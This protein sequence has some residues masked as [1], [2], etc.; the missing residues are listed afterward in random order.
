MNPRFRKQRPIAEINIT[1]FTDVIL[2]LLIIFMVT[3]PLILQ[4]NIKINLP[5]AVSGK[6]GKTSDQIYI[7]INN[8]GVVYLDGR[9]VTKL[10]LREKVY[11]MHSRNQD[12]GAA[13]LADRSVPFKDIVSVLDILNGLGLKHLNIATK[14]DSQKE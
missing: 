8:R 13:L 5:N 14:T 12:L 9:A 1:P 10:E 7:S 6:A 11:A 2:V 4:S 3:T